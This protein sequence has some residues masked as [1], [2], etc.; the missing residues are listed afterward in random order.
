MINE[1]IYYEK[2]NHAEEALRLS[3]LSL[4]EEAAFWR[5]RR[6]CNRV[7]QS[8]VPVSTDDKFLCNII[9]I[10]G[11]AWNEIKV[12]VLRLFDTSSGFLVFEPS[13]KNFEE[14]KISYQKRADAAKA[15]HAKNRGLG[16][17]KNDTLGYENNASLNDANPLKNNDSN[18]TMQVQSTCNNNNNNNKSYI[19]NTTTSNTTPTTYHP[20]VD[21]VFEGD[22]TDR[23][24]VREKA[25]R[26]AG[27]SP[28]CYPTIGEV[29]KWQDAGCDPI[30]DIFPVIKANM[31]RRKGNS[32]NSMAYFTTAILTAK[33]N[34]L[35]PLPSL[36]ENHYAINNNQKSKF[37]PA[38]DR[39]RFT[40][41]SAAFR[42]HW[43]RTHETGQYA[44]AMEG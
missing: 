2:I 9:G 29:D 33:A 3:G 41:A 39:N 19:I 6:V 5:L 23:K 10:R 14:A 11:A 20:K 7:M 8:G 43:D 35:K 30:L 21:D 44:K 32:P 28:N 25:L 17:P 27:S 36:K 16:L 42:A 40:E 31:E 26:L 15:R 34:R 1:K 37:I 12:N 4:A 22:I 18:S 24:F 13:L 38:R